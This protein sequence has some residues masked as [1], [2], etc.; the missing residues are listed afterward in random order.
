MGRRFTTGASINRFF[1]SIRASDA[2][3]E[4]EYLI[5]QSQSTAKELP[6]RYSLESVIF[7]AETR[8]ANIKIKSTKQ[9]RTI[10]RYVTQDYVRYPVYSSWKT[11]IAYINKKIKLSNSALESLN[12][13]SDELI[14]QFAAEIILSLNDPTLIPSWLTRLIIENEYSS[15][16]DDY[17]KQIRDLENDFAHR[18]CV[19]NEAISSLNSTLLTLRNNR[20]RLNTAI[21]KLNNKIECLKNKKRSIPL[22][23]ITLGIYTYY[24][25]HRREKRLNIKLQIKQSELNNIESQ[26]NDIQVRIGE[27]KSSQ[28]SKKEIKD[29]KIATI[30]QEINDLQKSFELKLTEIET[31]AT[32]VESSD[33]IP[34][35]VISGLEYKKIIGCYIIHNKERDKYY[36]GQSKDVMKRLK[37]HFR[38]TTPNNIIFAEDYFNSTMASKED[39]FE[40]RIIPLNTKDELD[41]TEARLIE[42]YEAN[43]KGYNS[44][45]GNS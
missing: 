20:E 31:L 11:K 36:V 39:I 7:D 18:V 30:R 42:E 19:D 2:R 28:K 12:T 32:S 23:I 16:L 40:V 6:I 14:K 10:E 27:I 1:A 37:Q 35:K 45:K 25:S 43:T 4:R 34:L 21:T 38:G 26:I 44:T 15:S 41:R 22:S 24:C 5:N 33:Y 8:I 17:N 3:K 13:H 29:N 9:Y